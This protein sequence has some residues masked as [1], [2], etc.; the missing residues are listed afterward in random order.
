[1]SMGTG[2]EEG[3]WHIVDEEQENPERPAIPVD[4][5]EEGAQ[6]NNLEEQKMS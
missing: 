2:Q 6:Q 3:I 5:S 1:M 4:R